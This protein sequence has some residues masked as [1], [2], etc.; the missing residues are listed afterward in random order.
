MRVYCACI[1]HNILYSLAVILHIRDITLASAQ[2]PHL[3]LITQLRGPRPK[4]KIHWNPLLIRGNTYCKARTQAGSPAKARYYFGWTVPLSV[5]W[6]RLTAWGEGG[7]WQREEESCTVRTSHAPTLY[8]SSTRLWSFRGSSVPL[9]SVQLM[10][11]TL[12]NMCKG[13]DRVEGG[14]VM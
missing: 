2:L 13:R 4:K 5:D 3:P 9:F 14:S 6:G 10:A 12:W 11:V 1:L 8:P 7:G